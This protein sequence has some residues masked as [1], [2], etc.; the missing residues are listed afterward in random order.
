MARSIVFGLFVGM[1]AFAASAADAIHVAIDAMPAEAEKIVDLGRDEAIEVAVLGSADLDVRSIDP[2]SLRFAGAPIAKDAAGETHRL[3]D[4]NGDGS[5]DL[6]V[7]FA[8]KQLR[9]D[10][11]MATAELTGT[12]WGGNAVDGRGEVSAATASRRPDGSIGGNPGMES[13][14]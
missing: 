10:E 12:T 1:L 2:L 4:V 6:V 13:R 5:I 9:L 8:T 14:S 11:T 7:R 3:E